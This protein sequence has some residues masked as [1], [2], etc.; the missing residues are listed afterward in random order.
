MRAIELITEI[1]RKLNITTNSD[2]AK[3][4]GMT[5]MALGLWQKR[6]RPLSALQVANALVK[7][8]DAAKKTAHRTTIQPIVE[9]FPIEKVS[10]GYTQKKRVVFETGKNAGQH[11]NG[12][13]QMLVKTQGLYIFYDTR[14]KAL[15]AGQ[16]KKQNLWKEL[17]LA[18]NRDRSYQVMTL[19]KHPTIDVEFKPAHLKVRQP[20][21]IKLKLHDLAAYFSAYEVT[22]EMIDDLEALLV[23]AFPNDLLNSK[24][25]KFAK[26]S[27]KSMAVKAK[28]SKKQTRTTKRKVK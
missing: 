3:A 20:K 26:A 4:L 13:R 18:F 21:D 25:E 1:K 8:R 17:N 22:N 6:K 19:V 24:M 14:G 11:E 9:F 28:P 15:Y 23:R 27:K 10:V 7:A 5:P 16:T 12:L 2:L